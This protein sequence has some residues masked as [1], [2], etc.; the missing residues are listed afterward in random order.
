MAK[1][2][3]VR[4]RYEG[5]STVIRRG[6]TLE[7]AQ[8]HCRSED[9][10]GDGW[11]DGYDLETP[12]SDTAAHEN[13]YSYD[14]VLSA[15]Y[16]AVDRGRICDVREVLYFFEKPWHYPEIFEGYEGRGE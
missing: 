2:K 4:F 12:A 3:I 11:F 6:L 1:Y 13:D 7:E 5:D 10:R 9:T 16:W 8:A 14:R 15:A